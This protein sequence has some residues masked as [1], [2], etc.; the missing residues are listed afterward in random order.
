MTK[1]AALSTGRELVNGPLIRYVKLRVV[2]A[3]GMPGT[4]SP[5]PTSKEI[6]SY[7]SRR[8]SRHVRHARAVMHVRI[9]NPRWRGKLYRHSRRMRNPQFFVSGK[10]PMERTLSMHIY[11]IRNYIVG[12]TNASTGFS[13]RSKL[14]QFEW[15]DALRHQAQINRSYWNTCIMMTSSKGNIFRVTRPLRWESTGY[16]W[17]PLTKAS[18]AKLWCFLWSSPE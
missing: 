5:P 8:A 6:A 16:W 2:H 7:R 15:P 1:I 17:I 13:V 14:T 10:R 11:S 4:F 12:V 18:E 3:P 9:D